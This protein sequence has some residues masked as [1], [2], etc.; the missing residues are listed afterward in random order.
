MG[1][2]ANLIW[3]NSLREGDMV[4]IH[5][6]GPVVRVISVKRKTV[7]IWDPILCERR[8]YS[9]KELYNPNPINK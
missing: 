1:L 4:R 6:T 2:I 8:E 9:K 5:K 3:R 7:R